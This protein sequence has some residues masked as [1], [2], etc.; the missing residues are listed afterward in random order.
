MDAAETDA[1]ITAAIAEAGASSIKD[2]GKVMAALKA[3]YSG[4]MDSAPSAPPSS[5]AG[6]IGLSISPPSSTSYG[7]G[8]RCPRL[9]GGG[10]PCSGRA[11]I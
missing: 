11:R 6:R 1:A 9:S 3:K 7:R 5:Q 4:Q 10:S 2:M 8:F